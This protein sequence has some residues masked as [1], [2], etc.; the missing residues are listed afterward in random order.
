MGQI[1]NFTASNRGSYNK[2]FIKESYLRLKLEQMGNFYGFFIPKELLEKL[3]FTPEDDFELLEENG[4]LN[5]SKVGENSLVGPVDF[6]D[7][8]L[9]AWS[10]ILEEPLENASESE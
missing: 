5:I 4:Q 7:E 3:D 9:D 8:D 2:S 1:E 10:S 6:A